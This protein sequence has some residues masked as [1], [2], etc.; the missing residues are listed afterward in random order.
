MG[1]PH[2][3]IPRA[4]ASGLSYVKVDEPG[5]LFYITYISVEVAHHEIFCA[6]VGKGGIDSPTL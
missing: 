2:V 3:D 6:N 4:L 1:C 5:I